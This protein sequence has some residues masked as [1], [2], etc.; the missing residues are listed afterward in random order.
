MK[1]LAVDDD[2]YVLELLEL[3]LG[4]LGHDVKIARDGAAALDLVRAETFDIV[5]T[6]RMMPRLDGLGLCRA[7]RELKSARYIYLVMLT[8]M[9]GKTG[10]LDGMD[11]G[12]DD[13]IT[14]PFDEEEL[15]ARLR[16][17]ERMLGLQA[18][19]RQL[20]GL[21]PICSYCKSIRD[22]QQYWHRVE[23]YMQKFGGVHFSHGI[24]PKCWDEI[25]EPELKQL[26]L[27]AGGDSPRA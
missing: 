24:C 12:A 4:K 5:I 9:G 15:A 7:I 8:A 27:Q 21:L 23:H 2:R 10:F 16:V 1:I 17:A 22:D 11:A 20:E 13:F 25:V 18:E 3:T 26:D 6:D 14:K 19:V